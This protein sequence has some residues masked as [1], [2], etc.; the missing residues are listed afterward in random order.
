M[1][2]SADIVFEDDWIL[3][4][5]KPAGLVVNKS[6]T[7]KE[8]TLQ[9]ELMEYFG[10]E[11]RFNLGQGANQSRLNLVDQGI[12]GRAGIVHRLDRETSGLLVVA[13]TK[14]AFENLQ[15]QFKGREVEKKYITLVHGKIKDNGSVEGKIAR[16]GR[17][18]KFGV[19]DRRHEG[20]PS[21]TKV[22][23]G[24]EARTDF[25][26]AQ[27][28]QLSKRGSTSFGDGALSKSR[29]N[30]LEHHAIFYTLLDVFPKT[31]RTHQIRVHLKS[32][33][34]PV[35]SDLIYGPGKLLKFDLLWCPRLFLH[36]ASL[37][38]IH[39][40]TKKKVSFATDLPQ[41]LKSVLAQL[42]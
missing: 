19:V 1:L 2:K 31:G 15:A 24:K 5:N 25:E 32:I 10:K 34:H 33:G 3:V 23:E 29:L 16:I 18:G 27:R 17:F 7:N 9:D 21:F 11:T 8:G 39:P 30:Y 6:D 12:G 42:S 28:Y 37:S 4:V 40:K 20:K 26:V 35:V 13:K 14:A 41:D 38:F 22:T 36:A